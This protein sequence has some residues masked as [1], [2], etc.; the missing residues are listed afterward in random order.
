MYTRRGGRPS[1]RQLPYRLCVS[2]EGQVSNL[3]LWRKGGKEKGRR[4]EPAARRARWRRRER[5]KTGDMVHGCSGT[6]STHQGASGLPVSGLAGPLPLSSGD[7]EVPA[8]AGTTDGGARTTDGEGGFQTR[9]Y[10]AGKGCC[11][12]SGWRAPGAAAALAPG[13]E[14]C[15][16]CPH[17]PREEGVGRRVGDDERGTPPRPQRRGRYGPHHAVYVIGALTPPGKRVSAGALGMM[18]AGRPHAPSEEG[19]TGRTTPYT[20]SVPSRPQGR[21]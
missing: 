8:F 20:S 3:S 21:G 10:G 15:G 16:E 4:R 11:R 9:P 13:K 5:V 18:S 14:V 19:A 12:W 17:A 1:A 7:V 6:W 2:V